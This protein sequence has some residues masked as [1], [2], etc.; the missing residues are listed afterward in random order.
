MIPFL[1]L[2]IYIR[3]VTWNVLTLQFSK[4]VKNERAWTTWNS[5]F[6]MQYMYS[7]MQLLNL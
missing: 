6:F 3:Q 4:L 1:N 2:M 7:N 5:V